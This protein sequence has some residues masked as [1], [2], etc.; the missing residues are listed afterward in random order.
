MGRQHPGSPRAELVMVGTELLLGQIV[1]SNASYLAQQLAGIGL[2]VYHKTTVGDNWTRIAAVLGHAIDR[3]DVV[4][5]SGGLG[6]TDDDLTK[7]V[8]AAVMGRRLVLHEEALKDLKGW[9]RR[10]GRE[11]PEGNVKQV[12]LPEG[13]EPIP[14][15]LG[16]APGVL[17]DTGSRVVIC[18]PGVPAEM[19]SMMEATVLPYLR[20]R[21]GAGTVI[22]SR[23][24][25]FCGIGESSLAERVRPW[26][27]GS[28]PT[29]AP[30]AGSGEVKLRITARAESDEAAQRLIEP[31]Q[32]ELEKLG[33]P[34]L[35]GYDDELMETVVGRLL[36]EQ[37][38]TVA[39]A[40]SCTGGLIS[41]RLT[42]VPGSSHYFMEGHVTYSNEAKIRLLGVSDETLE[43]FGAV[44]RETALEMAAGVRRRAGTDVGLAS[45]GIAGP[46]GGTE[47]KPVGL[48]YLAV[49]V[50]ERLWWRR[51]QLVGDR[52]R[53]KMMSAQHALDGLRR[54]L[55]GRHLLEWQEAAPGAAEPAQGKGGGEAN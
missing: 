28:N 46:G 26:L 37:R 14:N 23:T 42:N 30:Y 52:E 43:A 54:I 1:D 41:H 4:I 12:M 9:F 27:Q 53:I 40:E 51:L 8:L 7:D 49:A 39:V 29:V 47:E 20:Q 13:A 3:A 11:M 6:P 18:L 35:Y 34:F 16:T 22:R 31:V 44:S 10:Q 21:F 45:T 32:R 2:N 48:V 25:R 36:T 33:E 38:R 50:G 24:L 5:T 19:R 55:L 17:L 15:A